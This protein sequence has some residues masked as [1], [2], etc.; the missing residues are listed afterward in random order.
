M[1]GWAEFNSSGYYREHLMALLNLV[2][3]SLDEEVKKKAEIATDLLL[4]DLIR[5]SHKGSMGA[6]GGRSQFKSKNTGWDNA[7]GDVVEIILGSRGA[8]LN[9]EGDIGS[10]Y[11]HY[12]IPGA[13]VNRNHLRSFVDC[14]RVRHMR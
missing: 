3:F 9:R 11:F 10:R 5:F 8:F 4:F 13:P 1:F 12:K 7:L 14:L 6:A 2:D